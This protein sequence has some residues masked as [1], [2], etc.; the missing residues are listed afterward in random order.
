VAHPAGPQPGNWTAVYGSEPQ[1]DVTPVGSRR[2]D[3]EQAPAA[4]KY[5]PQCAHAGTCQESWVHPRLCGRS[6]SGI[7]RHG[8]VCAGL[9]SRRHAMTTGTREAAGRAGHRAGRCR[10]GHD[11]APA[12]LPNP[13]GAS[14]QAARSAGCPADPFP[15]PAG[16]LP[17][18]SRRTSDPQRGPWHQT[19]QRPRTVQSEPVTTD[20]TPPPACTFHPAATCQNRRKPPAD[21]SPPP[22]SSRASRHE[23]AHLFLFSQK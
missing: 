14:L 5:A 6:A 16:A 12:T 10:S 9:M 11:R 22:I 8:G 18:T 3:A 13:G 23:V 15:R 1:P 2:V 21:P 19:F 17:I 7:R 4:W 20:G